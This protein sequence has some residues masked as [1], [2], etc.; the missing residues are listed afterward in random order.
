[1]K[2]IRNI[3]ESPVH[4]KRAEWVRKRNIRRRGARL[5]AGLAHEKPMV[6]DMRIGE[7]TMRRKAPAPEEDLSPLPCNDVARDNR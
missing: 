5:I 3:R 4:G 6:L 2:H 7:G 1:L